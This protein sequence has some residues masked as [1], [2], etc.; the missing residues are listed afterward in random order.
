MSSEEKNKVKNYP[1]LSWYGGII[2]HEDKGIAFVGISETFNS[3][4]DGEVG[5]RMLEY[6]HSSHRYD[7]GDNHRKI[8]EAAAT[9]INSVT[10]FHPDEITAYMITLQKE[11]EGKE[12]APFKITR[13]NSQT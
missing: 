8:I 3:L 11:Y 6:M 5:K 13:I 2:A 12:T 10:G 9:F 4:G 7:L 1:P